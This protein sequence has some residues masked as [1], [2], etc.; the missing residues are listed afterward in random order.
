MMIQEGRK[1][2][3]PECDC[4]APSGGDYC[5]DYCQDPSQAGQIDYDQPLD[6]GAKQ[7]CNCGHVECREGAARTSQSHQARVT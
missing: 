5:S 6:A 4:P 2:A 7:V 1:C 3:N